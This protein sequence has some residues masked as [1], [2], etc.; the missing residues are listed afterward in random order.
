M[1]PVF[2]GLNAFLLLL[3]SDGRG[4]LAPS[5]QVVLPP[6]EGNGG[7]EMLRLPS[8]WN[9]AMVRM[10]CD[11]WQ[12]WTELPLRSLEPESALQHI[13]LLETSV[14]PELNHSPRCLKTCSNQ[15]SCLSFQNA[16]ILR[17]AWLVF[18]NSLIDVFIPLRQSLIYSSCLDITME[19]WRAPNSPDI[20]L[21]LPPR[22]KD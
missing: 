7:W 20:S 9:T 6:S 4:A 5:C 13:V 22:Y 3:V 17:T 10:L 15:S 2:P 1:T 16:S 19:T 18:A 21:P 11:S 14:S 12:N 8:W